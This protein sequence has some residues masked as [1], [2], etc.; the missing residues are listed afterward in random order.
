MGS[1]FEKL[2]TIIEKIEKKRCIGICL[3]TAHLFTAGYP[4]STKSEFSETMVQFDKLIGL[5]FLKVIHLNDS[6]AP[7]NSRIDH[8][9]HIGKGYIG[10][11]GFKTILHHPALR[12]LPFILET[13]K[14]TPSSDKMNMSLARKLYK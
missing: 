11:E 9:H 3:D 4:L 14:S 8:H 5:N 12:N 13:P 10:I 1:S 7:K 6:M 2:K